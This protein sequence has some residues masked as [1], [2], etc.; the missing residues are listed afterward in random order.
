MR[1]PSVPTSENARN[2]TNGMVF[3]LYH[4]IS[5]HLNRVSYHI[6][7]QWYY[8]WYNDIPLEIKLYSCF[9]RNI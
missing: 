8:P 9:R 2:S 7:N 3:N 5:Y 6:N 4:I 1:N